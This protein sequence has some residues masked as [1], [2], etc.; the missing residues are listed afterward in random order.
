MYLFDQMVFLGW[1]YKDMKS[2][3]FLYNQTRQVESSPLSWFTILLRRK[4]IFERQNYSDS[5][6]KK[7]ESYPQ[8][9]WIYLS[10]AWK[11]CFSDFQTSSHSLFTIVIK[12][13]LIWQFPF[14]WNIETVVCKSRRKRISQI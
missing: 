1:T 5:E 14:F 10:A 9:K 11:K 7:L 13:D 12:L 6:W 3:Q 4:R 8:T 2:V